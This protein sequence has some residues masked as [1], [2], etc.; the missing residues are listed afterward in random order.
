M[1]MDRFTTLAQQALASAQSK[2]IASSHPELTPLHLLT[3]MLEERGGIAPSILGKAGLN[4]ERITHWIGMGA[5]PSDTV[6]RLLKRQG[7]KDMDKFI[8]RY[9]KRKPKKEPP[10]V[11]APPPPA[12]SP[13]AT[14]TVPAAAEATPAPESAPV[15][16]EAAP[17]PA[18]EEP[19]TDGDKA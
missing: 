6:A 18:A 10:E 9:T 19:A 2:A 1:N 3:A 5:I 12:P 16:E 11:V 7:M 15:A 8:K 14:E 4:A 13:A 17:A